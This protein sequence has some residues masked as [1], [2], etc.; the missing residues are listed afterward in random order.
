MVQSSVIRAGVVIIVHVLVCERK[1]EKYQHKR[2]CAFD[3]RCKAFKNLSTFRDWPTKLYRIDL[4]NADFRLG[5]QMNNSVQIFRTDF[6]YRWIW[7][8]WIEKR[9]ELKKKLLIFNL[10]QPA[11]TN[12]GHFGIFNNLFSRISFTDKNAIN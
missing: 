3:F 4:Y 10:F 9:M 8:N 7:I 5:L 1:H 11:A 2:A 6:S 12:S